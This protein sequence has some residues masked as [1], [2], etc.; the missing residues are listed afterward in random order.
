MKRWTILVV[1]L[2]L[3]F[4]LGR[5]SRRGK[6]R[7]E[8]IRARAHAANAD[9]HA[10]SAHM[11]ALDA[12]DSAYRVRAHGLGAGVED[13]T[14]RGIAFWGA[15]AI[16]ILVTLTLFFSLNW[17]FM[18]SESVS[19]LVSRVIVISSFVAAVGALFQLGAHY[20]DGHRF[21]DLLG[22]S[23][24]ASAA[25]LTALVSILGALSLWLAARD[26]GSAGRSDQHHSALISLVT[27]T[28]AEY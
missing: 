27:D 17:W 14:S 4:N 18:D 6:N 15:T 25:V 19:D 20:Q 11:Q 26:A 9:F 23:L 24:V 10:R 28:G 21:I 1:L 5:F 3:M 7:D 13:E 16:G 12:A 2:G 8:V 22:K